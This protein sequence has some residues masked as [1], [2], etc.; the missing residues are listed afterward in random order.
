[1]LR[2]EFRA[3]IDHVTGII[4]V[5]LHRFVG[6]CE[7]KYKGVLSPAIARCVGVVRVMIPGDVGAG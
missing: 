5:D 6:K 2:A 4:N 3:E 7:R 1:M